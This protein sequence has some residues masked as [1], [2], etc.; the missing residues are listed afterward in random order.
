MQREALVPGIPEEE[1]SRLLSDG[2]WWNDPAEGMPVH[3]TLVLAPVLEENS[4][5][6]PLFAGPAYDPEAPVPEDAV[7]IYRPDYAR[8]VRMLME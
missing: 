5:W 2:S 4:L 6:D 1:M 8:G 7:S 3:L